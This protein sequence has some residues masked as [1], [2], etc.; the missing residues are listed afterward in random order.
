[1][2]RVMLLSV[3][4]FALPTAALADDPE[5]STGTFEH[6]TITSS[7][8]KQFRVQVVGSMDTITVSIPDLDCLVPETKC[9]FSSGTV[10]VANPERVTVFTAG[11]RPAGNVI[12]GTG[13]IRT[14]SISSYLLPDRLGTGG[15]EQFNFKFRGD[16]IVA[17]GAEVDP[18]PE[19]GTLEELLLGTGIIGLAGMTR[20]K[21]QLG[22]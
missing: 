13:T 6:G 11:L 5:F 14:V 7:F 15:Y 19:P 4:A 21:F 16:T 20:C 2:R 12:I 3:L 9:Y 22:T 10:T 1:M 18:I 17:G 8:G